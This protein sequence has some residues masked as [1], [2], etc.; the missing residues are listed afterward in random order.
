[1]TGLLEIALLIDCK[2]GMLA[3]VESSRISLFR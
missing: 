1:M 3:A 2:L